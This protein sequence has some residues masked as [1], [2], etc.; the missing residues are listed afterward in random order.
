MVPVVNAR[1]LVKSA[2][3]QHAFQDLAVQLCNNTDTQV[4][5][6]TSISVSRV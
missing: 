5:I 1:A 4:S 6:L 3:P 2:V